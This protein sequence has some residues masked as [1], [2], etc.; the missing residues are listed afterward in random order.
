MAEVPRA[1]G[2]ALGA[3]SIKKKVFNL[4]VVGQTYGINAAMDCRIARAKSK[5]K[6][7]EIA[8][9]VGRSARSSLRLVLKKKK[10]KNFSV[11]L[12]IV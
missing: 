10:K 7:K 1:A 9:R 3:K 6:K 11:K 4:V 2:R 5:K 12:C 8:F